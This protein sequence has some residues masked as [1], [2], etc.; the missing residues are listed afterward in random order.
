MTSSGT[1]LTEGTASGEVR[2]DVA[3]EELASYCLHAVTAA[4]GLPSKAAV[5]RLVTV[6]LAGAAQALGL[7]MR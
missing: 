5:Q 4:R 6:I 7:A 2:D 3:P 1:S